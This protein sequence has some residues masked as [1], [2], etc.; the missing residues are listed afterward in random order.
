MEGPV[1]K[2]EKRVKVSEVKTNVGKGVSANAEPSK[3]SML[4]ALDD[5]K[6]KKIYPYEALRAAGFIKSPEGYLEDDPIL[7]KPVSE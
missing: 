7:P 5:G 3:G 1:T 4:D 6:K 2:G